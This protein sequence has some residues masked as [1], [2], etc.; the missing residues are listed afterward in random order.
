[1]QSIK[2]KLNTKRLESL[3]TSDLSLASDY[4]SEKELAKFK[5]PKKKVR[6]LREKEKILTADDLENVANSFEDRKNTR[7]TKAEPSGK[8]LILIELFFA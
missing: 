3:N 2:E 4:Y 8:K 1:M 7:K 6:K 5:K